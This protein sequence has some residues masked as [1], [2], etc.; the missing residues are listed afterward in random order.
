MIV[1]LGIGRFRLVLAFTLATAVHGMSD[2]AG[3]KG[4]AGVFTDMAVLGTAV[5]GTG[6]AS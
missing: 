1:L 4:N 3:I 6:D 5:H 2:E